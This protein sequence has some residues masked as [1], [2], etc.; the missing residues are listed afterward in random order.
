MTNSRPRTLGA[1]LLCV[2]LSNAAFAIKDTRYPVQIPMRDGQNLAGD[3]YLPSGAGPWP[4]VVVQTPYNKNTFA[5]IFT[6]ELSQNPL[7]K[8]PDYA[9]VV[10]DWRGFF[11]SSGAAYG[12]SPTRGQD[13]YDVVEWAGTQ[14]WSSGMVGT[15]GES[16]LGGVQ[17]STAVLKPPHLKACVPEVCHSVDTYDIWYPGGVYYR[18]RNEFVSSY[19]GAGALARAHPTYDAVWQALEATIPT[20]D[21]VATPILFISG[22]YD[23]EPWVTIPEY[24]RVRAAQAPSGNLETRLLIGPWSHSHLGETRQNEREYPAAHFRDATEAL[25]FFDRHLRSTGAPRG[26]AVRYF[27]MND[28]AWV[29]ADTWP[30]TA[31]IPATWFLHADGSLT[32]QPPAGIGTPSLTYTSGPYSPVPSVAGAVLTTTSY[33]TQGPGD[34]RTLIGRP[35]TLFFQTPPLAQPLQIVGRPTASLSL[36]ASTVDADVAARFVEILPDGTAYLFAEGIRRASLRNSL[37]TRSLLTPGTMYQVPVTANPVALTIPTGH[38]LGVI[39][40]SSSYDL[41]DMNPQDG[42]SFLGD[43]GATPTTAT[44]TLHTEPAALSKITLPLRTPEGWMLR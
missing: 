18:N 13:G 25:A 44:L 30:P 31:E 36:A 3:Y 40:A 4:V 33:A 22:W 2:V 9:W 24:Q 43:T 34:L 10:V 17:L 1:A 7:L 39:I 41:F 5:P 42:H 15:W 8:S 32:S 19:Y 38:R 20:Y 29:D 6:L 16:A 12:G 28:D 23:I 11:G 14:P 27:Q 35:D 26:P 37:T 21:G